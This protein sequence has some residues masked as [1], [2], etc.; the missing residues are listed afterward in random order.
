AGRERADDQVDLDRRAQGNG[1]GARKEGASVP[2]CEGARRLGERSGALPGGGTG[3]PE[4]MICSSNQQK[5]SSRA[6]ANGS[7]RNAARWREARDSETQAPVRSFG[8]VFLGPGS[9]DRRSS[10]ADPLA[11][12]TDW[13]R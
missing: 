4:G 10:S 3:V 9:R 1:S 2:A 13:R 7:A 5:L 6:S 11:G 12:M 8:A